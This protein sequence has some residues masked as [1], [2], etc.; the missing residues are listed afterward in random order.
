MLVLPFAWS[1]VTQRARNRH[2][3]SGA[4]LDLQKD[5]VKDEQ[6]YSWGTARAPEVNIAGPTGG[7]VTGPTRGIVVGHTVNARAP[8]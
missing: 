3:D 6:S 4:G 1:C 2:S 8:S 5:F 7:K